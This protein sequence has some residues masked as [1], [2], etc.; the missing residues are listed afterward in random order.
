MNLH[1]TFSQQFMQIY[2]V[3]LQAVNPPN[4]K[5]KQIKHAKIVKNNM[6]NHIHINVI[7]QSGQTS[8]ALNL[9]QFVMNDS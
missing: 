7:N 1:I 3:I 4:N 9:L 2:L 5:R 8:T 6:T